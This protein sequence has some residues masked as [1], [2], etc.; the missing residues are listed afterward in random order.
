[1]SREGRLR[2]HKS[3]QTEAD[4]SWQSLSNVHNVVY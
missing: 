3:L 1:M 2:V 4:E